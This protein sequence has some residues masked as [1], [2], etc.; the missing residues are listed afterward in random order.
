MSRLMFWAAAARKNC[1]RT[2]DEHQIELSYS[3]EAKIAD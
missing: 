1:S 2:S 3:W